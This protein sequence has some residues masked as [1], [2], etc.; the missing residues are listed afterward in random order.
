MTFFCEQEALNVKQEDLGSVCLLHR[1][2]SAASKQGRHWVQ[3]QLKDPSVT[4]AVLDGE[5]NFLLEKTL[6]VFLYCAVPHMAT[7]LIV[8]MAHVQAQLVTSFS[9]AC[10]QNL[11]AFS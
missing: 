2:I 7:F 1:Q 9:Y 11:M 4:K 6:L 5:G 3:S 10:S 8:S